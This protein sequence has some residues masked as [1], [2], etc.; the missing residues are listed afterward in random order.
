MAEDLKMEGVSMSMMISKLLEMEVMRDH[1]P[2]IQVEG[3]LDQG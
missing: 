1:S 2:S 3:V